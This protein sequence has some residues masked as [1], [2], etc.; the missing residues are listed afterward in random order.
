MFI[1]IQTLFEETEKW[2]NKQTFTEINKI[3]GYIYDKLSKYWS[4]L[5]VIGLISTYLDPRFKN[6][7]LKIFPII[8]LKIKDLY[9]EYNKENNNDINSESIKT[10]SSP[11]L[12]K[13]I[14]NDEVDN[15]LKTY[16]NLKVKINEDLT[17]FDLLN[18]WK[19]NEY[20]YPTLSK[21]AKDFL[22]IQAS[23]VSSEQLFSQ[24]GLVITDRRNK[25]NEDTIQYLM[26][27]RSWNELFNKK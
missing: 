10:I 5:Q 21:I 15:E 26:C 27:L 8:K 14:Q 17:K 18:W 12:K 19:V 23:S 11:F 13:F 4:D 6:E 24:S 3:S 22:S 7:I 2:K 20:I 25:L 1:V 9:D 16:E